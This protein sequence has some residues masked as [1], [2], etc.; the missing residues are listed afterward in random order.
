MPWNIS[1]NSRQGSLARGRGFQSSIGGFPTS[2]GGPPGSLGVP[3]PSSLDRPASRLT[4][5]SPIHGRGNLRYK[6]PRRS[7][8]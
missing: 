7:G 3:Y 6:Q 1:A 8:R 4:S 2:A 5:A